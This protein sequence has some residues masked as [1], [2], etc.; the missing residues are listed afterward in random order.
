MITPS[1]PRPHVR[2]VVWDDH[3]SFCRVWITWF[4]R[5]DWLR[6]HRFVGASDPAAYLDAGITPE[7]ADVA[8]QVVGPAGKAAGFEAVRTIL[9]ALPVSFFWAPLLRLPPVR[10][11]GDRVYRAVARRRRCLWAPGVGPGITGSG[12]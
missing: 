9:E 2:L 8:L 7:E 1:A 6:L 4:Q 12:G 5:L 3:C 10:W 11:A